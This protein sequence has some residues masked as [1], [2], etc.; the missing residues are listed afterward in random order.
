MPG[1]SRVDAP[2]AAFAPTH[3]Q[4]LVRRLGIVDAQGHARVAAHF[5]TEGSELLRVQPE[6]VAVALVPG[7]IHVRRQTAS[8]AERELT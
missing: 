4:S 1:A 6:R 5:L 3:C 2:Y 8:A 7:G